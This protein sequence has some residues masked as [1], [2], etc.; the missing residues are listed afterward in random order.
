MLVK[1]TPTLYIDI[2]FRLWQPSK[3]QTKINIA[4]YVL[5]NPILNDKIKKTKTKTKEKKTYL[6]D[7]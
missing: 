4:V 1:L 6:I 3:K 5:T 2:Y 7:G